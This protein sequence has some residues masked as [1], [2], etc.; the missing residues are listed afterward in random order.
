MVG[1]RVFRLE[2]DR[3][4]VI[5][6]GLVIFL[7]GDSNLPSPPVC[8]RIRFKEDRMI[9]VCKGVP[10]IFELKPHISSEHCT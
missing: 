7:P 2:L 6:D 1:E 5:G 4:R 3:L 10:K 9:Q 8:I